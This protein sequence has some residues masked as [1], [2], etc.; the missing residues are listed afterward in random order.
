MARDPPALMLARLF[1]AWERRLVA[2]DTNRVVRPFEWGLDWI[3][4]DDGAAPDPECRI[5]QWA[6]R[7]LS[8]PDW[9]SVAPCDDYVLRDNRLTFPSAVETP[10][11]E[12]S[13]VGL[14]YFP[15]GQNAASRRAV[16]VLPQWNS[17]R[18]SHVG[19][20]QLLARVGITALR[21]SLPYHD[22][23][24]PPELARA[25]YI[26][27]PNIARTLQVNRQAVLDARRAIAW[28]A[29][30]GH[31]RIGILGTSLGSCLAM[32]TAAHEPLIRAAALN[33]ISPYFAD[34]VWEGLSTAHVKA[35]LEGSIDLDR[36]RR[37]W[38]PISPQPYIARMGDTPSLLVYARY[39]LS[40]PVRLSRQL[41]RE[42][43][44][45]DNPHEVAV[46]PCGHYTTGKP[47]FKWLDGY[48]LVQFLR[49]TL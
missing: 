3:D 1:H 16:L 19:L 21:L 47:P 5:A 29:A 14:R 41:I 17:D 35:G 28:L 7:A 4:G 9:F 6:D 36:L 42:F 34:V 49:R 40:F 33:H 27:S 37:L 44:R 30:Q 39:D 12:N 45:H 23:R 15:A 2:V 11:P 18:E 32:L 26:V 48:L 43:E 22:E 10:H 46:L 13:L 8:D 24:M 31:D 38:L 25:D 20:C